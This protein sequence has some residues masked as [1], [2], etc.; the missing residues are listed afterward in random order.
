M[1]ASPE[2]EEVVAQ[3]EKK[4]KASRA[5]LHNHRTRAERLNDCSLLYGDSP[6]QLSCNILPTY[7]AVDLNVDYLL[8]LSNITQK[9]A[10]K[11]TAETIFQIY[12]RTSVH[13]YRKDF[14]EQKRA[15]KF[16]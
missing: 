15:D 4:K 12:S 9:E 10:I 3:K 5:S 16:R 8:N 2:P 6:R 14:I 7:A 13:P 1:S 11:Q